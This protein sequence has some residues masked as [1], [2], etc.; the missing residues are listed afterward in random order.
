[1]GEPANHEVLKRFGARVVELRKALDFSQE[2]LA[3]ECGLARS[4]IGEVERGKRNLSL[5]NICKLARTLK[6]PPSAMLEFKLPKG[7]G[8]DRER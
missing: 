6:V 2:G 4:Y 5:I 3:L 1:M 8:D 7:F